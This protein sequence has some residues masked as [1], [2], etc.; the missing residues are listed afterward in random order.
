VKEGK[1]KLE[2]AK[3]KVIMS[4]ILD[5]Y[6]VYYG[7]QFSGMVTQSYPDLLNMIRLPRQKAIDKKALAEDRMLGE[8]EI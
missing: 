1:I 6:K 5:T 3:S 8:K 2:D 7:K 4:A